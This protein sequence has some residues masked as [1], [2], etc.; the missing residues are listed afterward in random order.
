MNDISVFV[1]TGKLYEDPVLNEKENGFS[2]CYFTIQTS[3]PKKE[4]DG[5]WV[6]GGATGH[7]K[8]KCY[9]HI[10]NKVMKYATAGTRVV[11]KG[12]LDG[13]AWMNQEG[14]E[15]I[16]TDIVVESI[17]FEG[18]ASAAQED[19]PDEEEAKAD[20]QYQADTAK[21]EAEKQQA[22]LEDTE[23]DKDAVTD[24]DRELMDDE[25][26]PL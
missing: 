23:D 1:L 8:V 7:I 17:T 19:K 22:S 24:K 20:A 15:R 16:F 3:K 18:D 5:S 6:D 11:C 9:G 25:D 4:D 13:R 14:E 10:A 12:K 21:P 2:D 26:F